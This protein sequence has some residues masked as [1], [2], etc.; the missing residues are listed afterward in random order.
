MILWTTSLPI[1][2]QVT[3]SLLQNFIAQSNDAN[4]FTGVD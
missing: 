2:M 1:A 4:V 3:E